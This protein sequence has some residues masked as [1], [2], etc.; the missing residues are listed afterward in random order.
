MAP[1]QSF[2]E[3][4]EIYDDEESLAVGSLVSSTYT[5]RGQSS[6]KLTKSPPAS[7][8]NLKIAQGE[9]KRVQRMKA[10][11]LLLLALC[12]GAL[13]TATYL[14]TSQSE[15]DTFKSEFESFCNEI[16]A[17]TQEH[18]R[19]SI[20]SIES[21]ANTVTSHAQDAGMVW[22]NVTLPDYTSRAI[23]IADLGSRFTI[24]N[25]CAFCLS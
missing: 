1:Q 16:V 18:V 24:G 11:M 7:N 25:I 22:P 15:Q 21:F 8:P 2:P 23:S 13:A 14:L 12:A 17:V 4:M 10:T 9:Q 19:K 20:A 5:A 3:K 6:R